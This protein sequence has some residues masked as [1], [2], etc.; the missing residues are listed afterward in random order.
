M[1]PPVDNA[2]V[3]ELYEMFT[4]LVTMGLDA[5]VDLFFCAIQGMREGETA[6]KA[7]RDNTKLPVI[8]TMLFNPTPKGFR[9]MEGIEPTAGAEKLEGL[10][11]DIIGMQCGGTSLVEVTAVLKEMGAGCSKYL[12][13]KP[14]AGKPELVH[15]RTVWPATTEE[16]AKEASNWVSA[17]AR[18]IGGCCGVTPE[19]I[20]KI[21][22]AVR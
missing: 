11:V 16:M 17:G 21:V 10:G 15:G 3:D 1:L 8:A 2:T 20:A 22:A 14:N 7:I 4:E 18:V 6:I 19:H 12:I 5:G 9:T 13:A